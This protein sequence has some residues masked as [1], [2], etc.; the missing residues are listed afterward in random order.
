MQRGMS[1][2]EPP[3]MALGRLGWRPRPEACLLSLALA[4]F[5]AQQARGVLFPAVHSELH[6][7]R[8]RDV[9]ILVH[10]MIECCDRRRQ[11]QRYPPAPCS[12]RPS[13][14]RCPTG[15]ADAAAPGS[16]P[17]TQRPHPAG[18]I[19]NFKLCFSDVESK[20]KSSLESN[21]G[22]SERMH[23]NKCRG[24]GRLTHVPCDLLLIL[25]LVV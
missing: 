9:Q 24:Q 11:R 5:P 14:L 19:F 7:S 22:L 4:A 25:C 16:F 13:S 12:H 1:Q 10:G 18:E 20:V 2:H 23:S 17:K 6:V 15:E 3:A 8:A 21:K